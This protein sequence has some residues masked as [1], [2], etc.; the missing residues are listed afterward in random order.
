VVADAAGHHL[1]HDAHTEQDE[2]ERA[3]ELGGQFGGQGALLRDLDHGF[4]RWRL[5]GHG[6]RPA[7]EG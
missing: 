2:D 7:G 3:G 1:G 5:V 4:L 6:M